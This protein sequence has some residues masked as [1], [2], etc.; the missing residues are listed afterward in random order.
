MAKIGYF[1][2][3]EFA[4]KDGKESPWPHVVDIALID[5]CNKIREELGMAIVINSGYRSEEHNEAVGGAKSSYHVQGKAADLSPRPYRIANV[6]KLHEICDRLN[7]NGGVG[8]YNTFC[9]VD[10]RGWRARWD[11]RTR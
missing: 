11:E 4:S 7:P 9:H 2:T 5:L 10:V 6:K 3:K 8:F 1:D